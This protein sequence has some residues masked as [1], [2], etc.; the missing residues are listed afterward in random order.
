MAAV[1]IFQEIASVLPDFNDAV[2]EGT[3]VG[4]GT[5]RWKFSRSEKR[6][7]ACA[8]SV[9]LS[10]PVLLLVSM[11]ESGYRRDMFTNFLNTLTFL[12]LIQFFNTTALFWGTFARQVLVADLFEAFQNQEDKNLNCLPGE[13]YATFF[14]AGICKKGH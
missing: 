8:V 10:L 7:Q 9:G 3:D 12:F 5:F 11:S 14:I 1:W 2:E 4:H 6:V 13:S